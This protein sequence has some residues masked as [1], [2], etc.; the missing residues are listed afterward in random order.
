MWKNFS[1]STTICLKKL[2]YIIEVKT[3]ESRAWITRDHKTLLNISYSLYLKKTYISAFVITSNRYCIQQSFLI[4]IHPQA[5]FS[6]S[7]QSVCKRTD[8]ALSRSTA[9]NYPTNHPTH[10]SRIGHSPHIHTNSSND[11]Y[12]R[13]KKTRHHSHIHTVRAL[14][15]DIFMT[16]AVDGL[17]GISR[18]CYWYIA[19]SVCSDGSPIRLGSRASRCRNGRVLSVE[20]DGN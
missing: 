4:K 10:H 8:Y 13:R 20:H 17:K 19:R 9:R 11:Y 1:L 12:L 5:K 7:D 14:D 2:A 3:V 16:A 18:V 15:S 6:I